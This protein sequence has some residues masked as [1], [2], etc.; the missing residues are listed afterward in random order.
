[1]RCPARSDHVDPG[2]DLSAYRA[3]LPRTPQG[4][5]RDARLR[6]PTPAGQPM[7]R[8]EHAGTTRCTFRPP[9]T[10]RAFPCSSCS[11]D[12]PALAGC[13][14]LAPRTSVAR[15]S[16][17]S[18]DS[19]G[20]AVPG[21]RSW[22]RRIVLRRSAAA[23]TLNSTATGPYEDYLVRE[24]VPWIREKYPNRTGRGSRHVQ[25]RVRS[26]GALDAAPGPVP[27]SGLERGRRLLRVHLRPRVPDRLPGAP[28]GRGPGSAPATTALGAGQRFRADQPDGP[29]PRDDGLRFV[30]LPGR[31][32][33]RTIR[34]PV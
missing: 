16:V 12:T 24:I 26:P 8:P 22:S 9:A 23:R 29:G 5:R 4:K 28:E 31:D 14:L 1:M 17:A 3:G 25:R 21:K 20:P 7:G 15:S 13:T 34:A 32:R 18:T 6:K 19:S 27:G 2:S 30:L 10:P 33:T 11:A